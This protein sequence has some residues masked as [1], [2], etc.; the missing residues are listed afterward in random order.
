MGDRVITSE[1]A[2]RIASDLVR[3]KHTG[4]SSYINLPLVY[5]S[6]SNVTVKIDAVEQG[7]RVSD[8][9]FCFREIER[10]GGERSFKRT[11]NTFAHEA[12]VEVGNRTVFVD[13]P[14]EQ[15]ASAV[16]DVGLVSWR[17]AEKI[18]TRLLSDNEDEVADILR[19]RLDAVFGHNRVKSGKEIAGSS[20][21]KWK[22]SAIVNT[23]DSF[24]IFQAI[25][26]SGQS[27]NK[28]STA[29]FDFAGLDAP[30]K[31]IGVVADK[32]SFGPRLGI[33]SRVGAMILE[34]G[35]TNESYRRKVG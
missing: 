29:F 24:A 20:S 17:T 18:C 5:P 1:L 19:Q 23:G 28:A 4:I 31:M 6:G 8:A 22:V 25:S 21:W 27:I 9:G 30:P 7:V 35:E 15:A 3:V 2:D 32:K 26:P 13:V 16:S 11:A 33:I 14:P 34:A 12:Q 10:L